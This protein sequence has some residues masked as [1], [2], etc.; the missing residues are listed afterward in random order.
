MSVGVLI[1]FAVVGAVICASSSSTG[2]RTLTAI[3]QSS[4][5]SAIASGK[6]TSSPARP[7]RRA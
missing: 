5:V 2:F 1:L 7:S 3:A 4:A 6:M